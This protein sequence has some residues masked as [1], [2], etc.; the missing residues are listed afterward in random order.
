MSRQ[1]IGRGDLVASY[2]TLAGAGV[3]EPARFSLVERVAAAAAAGF[4]GIGL[5][6]DDY[7]SARARGLSD[8]ELRAVLDDHGVK[9]VELEFLFDW[10]RDDERGRLSR[11][12]E[13]R[14]YA[15]ADALRAR[16]LNVGDIQPAGELEPL[17]VVAERFGALCDRA[18]RHGLL[19]ALEF[20][21]WS[22]IADAATAW[23]IARLAGRPNGGILVDAYHYFR[24]GADADALRA[25]PAARIV[26]VQ[27][28]DAADAP[29]GAVPYEGTLDRRLP[30]DGVFDLVGLVRLLDRMGVTAPISVEIIS[31]EHHALPLEDAARRAHET[32]LAVLSR[33][34]R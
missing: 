25:I 7:E 15:V 1:S 9:V 2:F 29:P 10:A 3:G 26:A 27:L 13:D 5:T 32:T 6:A 28:D 17:A 34:R 11:V 16:H 31:P 19:V 21:P 12:I 24:G 33:A 4:S 20:L 8:A 14:L 30:G 23:E 18:A 22:D